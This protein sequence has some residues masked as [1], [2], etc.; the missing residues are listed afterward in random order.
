MLERF[1]RFQANLPLCL[2]SPL[3]LTLEED[4]QKENLFAVKYSILSTFV[5]LPISTHSYW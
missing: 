5:T 1:L 3:T 2:V 4:R